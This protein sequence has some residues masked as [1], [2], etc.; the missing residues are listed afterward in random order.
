VEDART[1]LNGLFNEADYPASDAM[2][3]KF[4]FR[5][6]VDPVPESADF[7][8][9]VGDAQAAQIRSDIEART[10]DMMAVAVRDTYGRVADVVGHMAERLRAFKPGANGTRAQ[11]TFHDSL[12]E[13]VRDLVSLLPA[14]NVTADSNLARI[15]DRMTALCRDDADSLR[16]NATARASVAAEAESIMQEVSEFLA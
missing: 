6:E 13:N 11:G 3:R 12:V 5:V 2:K 14:L 8:V 15:A 16:D 4:S 10:R 7:R 1:R 9:D